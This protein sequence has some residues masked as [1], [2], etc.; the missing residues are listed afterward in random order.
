[1]SL[2]LQIFWLYLKIDLIVATKH[3]VYYIPVYKLGP[4]EPALIQTLAIFQIW[5]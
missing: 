1:M 5:P 4:K 3:F 2:G